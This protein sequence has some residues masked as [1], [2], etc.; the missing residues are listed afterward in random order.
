M[1]NH[2]RSTPLRSIGLGADG[3]AGTPLWLRAEPGEDAAM[4]QRDRRRYCRVESDMRHQLSFVCDGT[5]LAA[6]L[7]EASGTTGLLIVSGGNEIRSGAHRGM[8]M[9]AAAR[10][11]GGRSGVPLR[12]PRD[13]RQRGANGGYRAAAPTSRPRRRVPRSRAAGEAHCRVRQLRR[14]ERACCSASRWAR[15]ADPVK[16]LG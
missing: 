1:P 13:R 10:R 16:S 2:S 12:S 3:I 14:G 11:G 4:A 8:A 15:S 7:D 6:T 9:L 5:T